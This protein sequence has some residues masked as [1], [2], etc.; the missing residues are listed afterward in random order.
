MK[1]KFPQNFASGIFVGAQQLLRFP[2]KDVNLIYF[3]SKLVDKSGTCEQKSRKLSLL[4][5]NE[6]E[7]H[8]KV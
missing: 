4:D 1:I 7:R 3:L 6:N 2:Y 5:W 8:E